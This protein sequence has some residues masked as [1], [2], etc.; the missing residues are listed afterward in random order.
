MGESGAG[1]PEA[2]AG[3]AAPKR[4]PRKRAAKKTAAPLSA[5]LAEQ[6]AAESGSEAELGT[7]VTDDRPPAVESRT[8]FGP[9]SAAA[10]RLWVRRVD[11]GSV[12]ARGV[13]AGPVVGSR[14]RL[15]A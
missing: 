3:E 9:T 5:P 15:R 14:L 4:A 11:L 8:D 1:A 10:D 6:S 12:H 13:W 7:Q 2:A